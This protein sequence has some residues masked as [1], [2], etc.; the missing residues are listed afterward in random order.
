MLYDQAIQVK[1]CVIESL[2]SFKPE[3]N[4]WHEKPYILTR[5]FCEGAIQNLF[6]PVLKDIKEQELKE[7]GEHKWHYTTPE[8]ARAKE[9]CQRLIKIFKACKTTLREN[10]NYRIQFKFI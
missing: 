7:R 10:P 4:K 3:L 8:T 6:E 1:S 9:D 5:Q 2:F